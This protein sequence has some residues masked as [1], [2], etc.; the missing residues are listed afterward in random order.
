MTVEREGFVSRWSRL[1][2]Q[3]ERSA[4]EEE[5]PPAAAEPAPAPAAAPDQPAEG[6]SVE[7]LPDPDSLPPDADFGVFLREQV[8]EALRRKALRRLWRSNPIISAVD[9]LDDYCEDFTDAATVVPALRTA[10]KVGKEALERAEKLAAGQPQPPT[11]G[12]REAEPEAA[13]EPSREMSPEE[14]G[15][16]G[17]AG[18]RTGRGAPEGLPGDRLHG[19]ERRITVAGTDDAT[20][21]HGRSRRSGS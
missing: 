15:E 19:D 5:A 11:P 9:M 7:E 1:K 21:R 17:G 4:R 10:Y 2:R 16:S 20:F 12:D 6:P 18:A 14:P 13:G 8:P 3:R